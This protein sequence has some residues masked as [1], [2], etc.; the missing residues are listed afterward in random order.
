MGGKI[1]DCIDEAVGILPHAFQIGGVKIPHFQVLLQT[2][3]VP[4]LL[5]RGAV[6]RGEQDL[7]ILHH[8]LVGQRL[9]LENLKLPPKGIHVGGGQE[10]GILCLLQFP[11]DIPRMV[12]GP[13]AF[14]GRQSQVQGIAAHHPDGR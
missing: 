7:D 2:L 12:H 9:L 3:H 13:G 8:R 10:E 14:C 5:G 11:S 4:C 6:L 1:G